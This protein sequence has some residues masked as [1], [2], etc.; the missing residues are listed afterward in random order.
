MKL[1]L[2]KYILLM[3]FFLFCTGIP[4]SCVCV[5][6]VIPKRGNIIQAHVLRN[7]KHCFARRSVS[8]TLLEVKEVLYHLHGRFI[9]HL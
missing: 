7:D 2:M 3:K 5:V 9:L 6:F 4:V 1:N 8:C